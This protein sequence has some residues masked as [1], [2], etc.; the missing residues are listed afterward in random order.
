ML[1]MFPLGSVVFPHSLLPLRIFEERYRQLTR[2]CLA[3]A[4]EFGVVL[5]DRGSEVGGGEQRSGL[6]TLVAIAEA[7]ETEDGQWAM[8]AVGTRRIRVLRWL[9]DDP[10]PRA[11]VIEVDELPWDERAEEAFVPAER[12]VRRSLALLAELDEPTAP[13]NIGLADERAAAAWQLAALSPLGPLDRQ[14]LLA[15]DEPAARL[16]RLCELVLEACEVLTQRLEKG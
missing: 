5:I 16:G 9:E 4:R 12:A 7:Q 14:L 1:P 2:D 8:L 10:Y 13:F 3:G 15:I 11:E 6:G